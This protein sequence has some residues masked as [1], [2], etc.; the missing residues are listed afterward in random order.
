MEEE[1]HGADREGAFVELESDG[2]RAHVGEVLLADQVEL[3]FAD[4]LEVER[5]RNMLLEEK[6]METGIEIDDAS[7]KIKTV[8]IFEDGQKKFVGQ[9]FEIHRVEWLCEPSLQ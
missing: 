2:L 1:I 3:M 8:Q 7:K 4:A 9:S 6:R 5:V